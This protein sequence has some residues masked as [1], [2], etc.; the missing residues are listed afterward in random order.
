MESQRSHAS[1]A[2]SKPLAFLPQPYAIDVASQLGDSEMPRKKKRLR[3]K[4]RIGD[5]Y[6]WIS[7]YTR[8]ELKAK[9]YT[10]LA[11][12]ALPDPQT[13]AAAARPQTV[14]FEDYAW[15]WFHL[16]KE[17][18]L[19]PS[20]QQMYLNLFKTH[21]FPAFGKHDITAISSD[22]LQAFFNTYHGKSKSTT[23]KMYITF[24]QVFSKAVQQD[25]LAKNPML[26][27]EKPKGTAAERKPVPYEAVAGLTADLLAHPSGL[28]P[29]L[30]L[31]CGLRRGEA[32]AL[33]A[34]SIQNG[35]LTV[36]QAVSYVKGKTIIGEP[37]TRAGYRTVPIPGFM[38]PLLK[39]KKGYL[40][41][42]SA[43]WCDSKYNRTWNRL[44]NE[45]PLLKEY[46]LHAL[47]HTYNML[48]RRAGV[49]EVT[50]Q[51][52]M[53]HDDFKTT[54][55]TYTHIDANDISEAE[56]KMQDLFA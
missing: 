37:K 34:A 2:V 44:R 19:R 26:A 33:N 20:T 41:G 31:H 46:S 50:R 42:G 29:L 13:A 30:C 11:G 3:K 32:L 10:L 17:N 22:A 47:R 5:T 38:L 54:A 14:T 27:V 16:Y 36:N 25:I 12:R 7:A 52:L 21:L 40:F 39:D 28:L 49:D 9:E 8:A 43:P 35:R 15:K 23:D 48:L 4:I 18:T 24:D 6:K 56:L 53:G 55:K 45:I 51:Y 1:A